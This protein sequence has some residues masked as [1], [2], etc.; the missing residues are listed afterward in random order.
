MLPRSGA[1]TVLG[2]VRRAKNRGIGLREF[3][4]EEE[5]MQTGQADKWLAPLCD[6]PIIRRSFLDLRLR[7][8]PGLAPCSAPGGG[9]VP[10]PASN[11]FEDLR[12]IRAAVLL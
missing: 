12:A 3:R 5:I 4:G 9:E 2:T 1:H 10:S 6:L 8:L 7:L 11:G